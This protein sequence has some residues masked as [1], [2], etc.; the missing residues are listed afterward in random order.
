MW[1]VGY[2]DSVQKYV[3]CFCSLLTFIMVAE[4]LK[5]SKLKIGRGNIFSCYILLYLLVSY[6]CVCIVDGW[7][8]EGCL[9][10][11]FCNL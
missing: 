4:F 7:G 3:T 10:Y 9:C 5:F 2:N 6:I 1:L 8:R 11:D